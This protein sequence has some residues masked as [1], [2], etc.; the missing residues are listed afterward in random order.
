MTNFEK[1]NINIANYA[2][3]TAI[4]DQNGQRE[5]SYARLNELSGRVATKLKARGCQPGDAV[6]VCMERSMEYVLAYIGVLKAGC[7]VVPVVLDYPKE[8]IYSILQ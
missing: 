7:V 1:F 6:M 2:Q 8:R 5:I 4:V 3:Q